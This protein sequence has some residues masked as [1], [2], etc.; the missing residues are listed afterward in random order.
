M[1]YLKTTMA[2]DWTEKDKWKM[3]LIN[4][5]LFFIPRSNPSYNSKMHLVKTW[6]I[7]FTEEGGYLKPWREIALDSSN[8]IVFAGPDKNNYGF[9]LDSN[10]KYEDFKGEIISEEDFEKYWN[11][12]DNEIF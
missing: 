7:E 6:L 1:K 10:M 12:S 11:L 9:W 8:N 5:F 2:T 4:K 3:N